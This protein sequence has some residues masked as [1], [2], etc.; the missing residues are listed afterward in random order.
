MSG[1]QQDSGKSYFPVQPEGINP[2]TG[3]FLLW[4]IFTV[5]EWLFSGK[6]TWYFLSFFNKQM[7]I[8]VNLMAKP[9]SK[10]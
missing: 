4:K 10:S 2:S 5:S 7:P 1:G 6:I 8:S 3:S 9:S